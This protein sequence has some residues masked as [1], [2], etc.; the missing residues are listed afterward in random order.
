MT[1][2][3]QSPI[4]IFLI[5]IV[6]II[7]FS[8]VATQKATTYKQVYAENKNAYMQSLDSL[9]KADGVRTEKFANGKLDN[10]SNEIIGHYIDSLRRVSM[11]HLKD[12]SIMSK[13]KI[14]HKNIEFVLAKAYRIA[15]EAKTHLDNVS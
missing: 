1:K 10:L 7:I 8:C 5:A 9:D 14:S 12:D 3:F 13:V 6:S 4:N 15:Q 11:N 2:S